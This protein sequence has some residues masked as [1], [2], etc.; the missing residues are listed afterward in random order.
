MRYVLAN[1]KMYPTVDEACSVLA[2][3]QA[4]LAD[5]LAA[6][7]T[8]PRVIVCPPF[9][10]LAALRGLA[11]DR[12]VRLGAQ[13]CH[14][15]PRGPYT[16]EISTSMLRGLVEYVMVGHSERRAA[17]ET[18]EQIAAKVAAVAGA[19]LVPIVFVGEDEVGDDPRQAAH[20]RLGRALARADPATQPLLV[21]YEPAWAIGGREPAPPDRV[22]R[23]V[24]HLK[25]A[26]VRLGTPDPVVLYGGAVDEDDIEPL[27]SLDNL[28]GVGA[29]RA[30]L[31]PES[32]LHII[33]QVAGRP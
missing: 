26:L 19:G 11:D 18:D 25:G 15:E 6:E 33:E 7:S 8:L 1:W 13:N 5:R 24:D 9:V 29:T 16:G 14:W 32:F 10:A 27:L 30:T 22:R 28:D 31:D 20:E 12:V 4:R 23:A 2:G 17:G 3:V 21:V